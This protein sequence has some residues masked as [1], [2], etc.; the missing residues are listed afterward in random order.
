[1]DASRLDRVG[2]VAG[3]L[4]VLLTFVSLAMT[5]PDMPE[6]MDDADKITSFYTDDS[7][8][9]MGGYLIDAFG[10][11]L[12]LVF[13]AA[14]YVRLG[15]VRR[16][17]LPPASFGAGIA[18]CAMF[19]LYDVVNLAASARVEE[20]GATV[21]EIAT[22]LNDIG[23]LALGVGATMFAAVFLVCAGLSALASGALP[24]W[25]AYVGFVVALGLLIP[26]ISYVFL[27]PLLLWVL[28]ASILMWMDRAP[29]AAATA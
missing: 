4:A 5:M 17:I 26:P 9:L 23:F 28:V 19:M 15:G 27:V 12:L 11:I 8:K 20:Q 24:R 22:T 6:F 25:L 29:A 7:G 1:M 21:P 10:T 18:M 2:P 13:V 3:V 16:G 14:L